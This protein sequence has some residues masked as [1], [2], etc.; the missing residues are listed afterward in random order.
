MA[1]HLIKPK[2]FQIFIG[3]IAICIPMIIGIIMW[4]TINASFQ[5]VY[6]HYKV[7][8]D[9]YKISINKHKE[10]EADMPE[11]KICVTYDG[12]NFEIPINLIDDVIRGYGA[13]NIT[14]SV[15]DENNNVIQEQSSIHRIPGY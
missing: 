15:L 6:I 10:F 2:F 9:Y 1:Q 3:I 14:L 12:K 4:P 11:A 8:D 13:N 5:K 7:G